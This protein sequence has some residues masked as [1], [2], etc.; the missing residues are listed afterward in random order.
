MLRT[1]ALI[2]IMS[3]LALSAFAKDNAPNL[4]KN[5]IDCAQFK[6][7][8]PQQ[9]IELGTAIF[10]LGSIDDINLTD[11]PVKPGFFKFDGIDLFSVLDQKCG[12][13]ALD[14]ASKSSSD[15]AAEPAL[16]V[17]VLSADPKAEHSQKTPSLETAQ[18]PP[19]T[20]PK[21]PPPVAPGKASENQPAGKC[22]NRKAVYVADGLAEGAGSSALIEIAFDDKLNGEGSSE[23]AIRKAKNNELEWTYKGIIK[24]GRFIFA[25]NTPREANSAGWFPLT[26]VRSVRNESVSLAQ[27]F[28][29]PNREG[30]GEALLYVH[31]LRSLFA[32][33]HD[34]HRF[35][36]EGKRPSEPLPE[37]YYFDRCE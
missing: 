13:A 23:F 27:S 21:K 1:V 32:S 6:K 12:T 11:Q 4:P 33:K 17:G 3:G 18:T 9:W 14:E 28:I 31:G 29:K 25:A 2:L 19:P 5:S 26:S 24:R 10:S 22:A 30:T 8:G 20:P 16:A 35:K 37:A 34:S 7:V 36:F 15:T